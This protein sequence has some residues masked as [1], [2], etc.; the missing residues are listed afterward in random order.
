MMVRAKPVDRLGLG[1]S[2]PRFDA[3]ML[4]LSLLVARSA[5]PVHATADQRARAGCGW[6]SRK[7]SANR[8]MFQFLKIVLSGRCGEAIVLSARP[9]IMGPWEQQCSS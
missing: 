5:Q 9:E 7:V 3:E 8:A 4:P 6:A 1:G 2:S